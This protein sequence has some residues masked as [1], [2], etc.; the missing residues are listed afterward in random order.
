[1]E[2][3]GALAGGLTMRQRLGRFVRETLSFSSYNQYT[4]HH[5]DTL[6]AF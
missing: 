2:L 1:M 3:I 6:R 4:L 5:T